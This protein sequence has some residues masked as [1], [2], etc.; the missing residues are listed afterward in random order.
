MANTIN[1]TNVINGNTI[2]A[3]DITNIVDALDGTTNNSIIILGDLSQG[4]ANVT[5]GSTS[6]AEGSSTT[7]SGTNSHAEGRGATATGNFS[8]AEGY[9]TSTIGVYSHAEGDSTIA[10]GDYSHAEGRGTIASG[11]Y[12]QVIGRWNS[13]KDDTSLFIVGNGIS[14]DEANRKDAFKVTHS[15]SIILPQTQ[16]VTP[17][18]PSWTGKDGEIVPATVSG[19]YYLYMW[20]NGAWRSGSFA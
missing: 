5:D 4:G 19:K 6:H 15:S 10:L 8:H 14:S 18:G 17:S 7:A 2:E 12:Q 3:T 20:M 11:S 9:Y 16:S 13:H 1:K